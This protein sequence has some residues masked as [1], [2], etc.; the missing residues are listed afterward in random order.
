M[1][2]G[3]PQAKLGGPMTGGAAPAVASESAE[4]EED[5]S[6]GDDDA[7]SDDNGDGGAMAERWRSDDDFLGLQWWL[8]RPMFGPILGPQKTLKQNKI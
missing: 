2:T 8:F 4:D 7:D 5:D 6:D 3:L 1:L